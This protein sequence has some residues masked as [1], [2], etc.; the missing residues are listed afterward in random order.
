[1]ASVGSGLPSH[2]FTIVKQLMS[3]GIKKEGYKDS[4]SVAIPDPEPETKYPYT[5]TSIIIA[6]SGK[7]KPKT[8]DIHI[9]FLA[10][11]KYTSRFF[12]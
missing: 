3:N 5:L 4:I 9:P 6:S 7:L 2:K 1:M 8:S 11:I 12:S 10:S